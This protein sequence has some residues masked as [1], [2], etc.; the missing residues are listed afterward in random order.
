MP[1]FYRLL[2]GGEKYLNDIESLIGFA[3]VVLFA[4]LMILFSSKKIRVKFPPTF[5][6]LSGVNRIRH[7][8]GLAVEDGTRL[9]VSLGSGSLIDPS[10]PSGLVGL[11]TLNRFG[12]L[13]STSDLPPLC[14]SGNGGFHL[15]SQDVLS[16]NA[17]ETNTRD[18]L[19]P[20]L[21]QMSGTTP[22][23]YAVGVMDAVDGSGTSAS[24]MIGNFGPEAGLICEGTK[25]IHAYSL[26]SSDSII[27][28]SVF[29]ALSDDTL[30]G[31]ELYALPAYLGYHAV[32]Q[33][34]LRVQDSARL[35]IVLLLVAGAAMKLAGLL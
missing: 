17:V 31:E 13:T 33:A 1:V 5:R 23:S 28:Q 16:Q 20:N 27:G 30:I 24:V 6:N 29:L 2:N 34:S 4:G 22:F 7:A 12:Q 8:I 15:L 21:A 3:V 32:H 9:H 14:T 18:M 11:S 19:D 26:A 25:N 10:N 35:V